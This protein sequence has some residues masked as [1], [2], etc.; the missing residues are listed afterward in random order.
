M[1]NLSGLI[2]ATT[3]L[4]TVFN[5]PGGVLNASKICSKLSRE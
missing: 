5:H 4:C 3:L 1:M 2:E